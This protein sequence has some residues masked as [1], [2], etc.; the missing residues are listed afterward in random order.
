MKQVLPASRGFTLIEILMVI[1]II[2]ILA[3]IAVPMY[4]DYHLRAK[5]VS[6]VTEVKTAAQAFRTF[7]MENNTYPA[8]TAAGVTPPE[9]SSFIGEFFSH[10]DRDMGGAVES[11]RKL[12]RAPR[13]LQY[14]A[15]HWRPVELGISAVRRHGGD[16]GLR[17]FSFRGGASEGRQIDRQQ[18][19]VHGGLPPDGGRVPLCHRG[20]KDCLSPDCVR[21]IPNLSRRPSCA[22]RGIVP[23]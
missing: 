6:L 23:R 12:D 5:A 3:T 21:D 10:F 15:V 9:A 17:P 14:D 11:L 7:K 20:L 8:D 22:C 19:S 4:R 16:F 18:Q 2:G 1:A 13:V